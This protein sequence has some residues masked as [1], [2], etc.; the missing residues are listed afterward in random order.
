VPYKSVEQA[1]AMHAKADRGEIPQ[2]VVDHFDEETRKQK[3]LPH[4]KKRSALERWA[5]K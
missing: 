1:A 2:K 5:K 3:K 4:S